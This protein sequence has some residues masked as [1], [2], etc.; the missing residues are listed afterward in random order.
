MTIFD[1]AYPKISKSTLSLP[2]RPLLT[3]PTQKFF[4]LLLIYVNLY[5]YVISL[6]FH[7][8]QAISLICSGD[9]VD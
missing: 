2:K 4:D 5:Q 1:H 7:L 9:T 8:S 6:L 3:M